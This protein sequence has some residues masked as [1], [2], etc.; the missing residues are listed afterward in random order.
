MSA[1][2]RHRVDRLAR[3]VVSGRRTGTDADRLADAIAALMRSR[4]AAA[5]APGAKRANRRAPSIAA[6]AGAVGGRARLAHLVRRIDKLLGPLAQ[7][8]IARADAE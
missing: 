3:A 5:G 7:A 4:L 6:A 2:D 1:L 8:E